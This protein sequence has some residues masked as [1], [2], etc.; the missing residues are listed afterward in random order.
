MCIRDRF[1]DV[2]LFNNTIMENIRIGRKGATA[3]S[4]THLYQI[5]V[6]EILLFMSVLDVKSESVKNRYYNKKQ[7]AIIKEIHNYMIKNID[8]KLTINQLSEQYEMSATNV[9]KYFTEVYGNSIYAYLKEY[10]IQQAAKML[11]STTD[12]IAVIA[13]NVGYDNASKFASSFKSVMGITPN[14]FRKSV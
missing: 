2:T 13:G 7:V 9:K 5:K 12:D 4:Y 11:K 8:K 1:Q 3:V 14:E 6:M 10:R